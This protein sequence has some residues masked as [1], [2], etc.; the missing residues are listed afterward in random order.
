[1][2]AGTMPGVL[3]AAGVRVSVGV[4]VADGVLVSVGTG[5]LVGVAVSAG[6]VVVVAVD[7]G[8]LVG[9]EASTIN[10]AV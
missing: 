9:A 2:T 6:A 4:A 5:V 7:D 1:M 10:E 8:V 3:V